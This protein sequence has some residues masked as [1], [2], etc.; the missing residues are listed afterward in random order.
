MF[1]SVGLKSV[2][3][4]VPKGTKERYETAEGWKD[5]GEI[6]EKQNLIK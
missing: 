6:I 2:A 5:F 4:T 3:L 1:Y